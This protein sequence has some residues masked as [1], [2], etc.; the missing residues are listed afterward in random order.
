MKKVY[1]HIGPHKT[2]TTHIQRVFHENADYFREKYS[3]HYP[4]D[5]KVIFG[6]HELVTQLKM[7]T[8]SSKELRGAIDSVSS[9]N[10]L[11]SSENFDVLTGTEVETLLSALSPYDVKV[12]AMYREP[13]LRL[14]SWWQEEVKHGAISTFP[15]YA[16]PHLCKPMK[17][18]IYNLEVV[19]ARY[20]KFLKSSSIYVGDYESFLS[21]AG[22][23]AF[24]EGILC[25][26]FPVMPEE[27]KIINKGLGA[28]DI[29]M[30]R[31]L[32]AIFW[33][34]GQPGSSVREKYLKNKSTL[35]QQLLSELKKAFES[36]FIDI[37]LGGL[38]QDRAIY[39]NLSNEYNLITSNDFNRDSLGK[40]RK[41]PK[42]NWYLER[43]IYSALNEV[44]SKLFY[45]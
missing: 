28:F 14:Y 31:I 16:L 15:E 23:E 32:N 4:A 7:N 10:I 44:Y 41:I 42:N 1:L 12:I 37:E 33:L 20:R 21:S 26:K 18:S 17:S 2:G 8:F 22:I 5:Y 24:F 45:S 25:V 34:N 30:I 38:F 40:L 29:E 36:S 13:S 11:L 39:Q 3:I 9:N 35:D 19:L 6:H 27:E 43:G